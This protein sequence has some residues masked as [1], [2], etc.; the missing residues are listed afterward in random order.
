MAGFQEKLVGYG[1]NYQ[2]TMA[3]FVNS[4]KLYLRCLDMLIQDNNLE[5]LGQ[6]LEAGD[7]HAAFEAAHTLKGVVANMGLTPLHK[8]VDH[9]TEPLRAGEPRDYSADYQAVVAEFAR[10]LDLHRALKE[11]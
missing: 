7:L 11:D 4:E 3:R 2:I 9:I 1:V 8:A 6:A 5:K 10:V